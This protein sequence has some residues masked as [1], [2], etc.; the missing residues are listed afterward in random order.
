M[1][2]PNHELDI[3]Q[4]LDDLVERCEVY[5]FQPED[6]RRLVRRYGALTAAGLD[7]LLSTGLSFEKSVEVAT[8]TSPR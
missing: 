3:L 6:L 5:G 7:D 8:E 4:R 2:Q 1:I